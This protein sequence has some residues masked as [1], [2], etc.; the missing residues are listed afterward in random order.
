[1]NRLGPLQVLPKFSDDF[2]HM[3]LKT[4][5]DHLQKNIE[6]LQDVGFSQHG[7]FRFTPIQPIPRP[8]HCE[9]MDQFWETMA[10]WDGFQILGLSPGR[11]SRAMTLGDP[12]QPHAIGTCM[13]AAVRVKLSPRSKEFLAVT[14]WEAK[15]VPKTF[16]GVTHD[17]D[18]LKRSPNGWLPGWI[19]S[20]RVYHI[21]HSSTHNK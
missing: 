16:P 20:Y 11:K 13:V 12:H 3:S 7:G 5:Q 10:P 15:P 2:I 19:V 9:K 17:W 1:M 8:F 18:D 21:T 14:S 4:E 6:K